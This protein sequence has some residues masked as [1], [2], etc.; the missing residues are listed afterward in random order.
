MALRQQKDEAWFEVEN[1]GKGIDEDD[2]PH[3]FERF[4]RGKTEEGQP[5]G[6]GLG[7]AIAKEITEKYGGSIHANSEPG[8]WTRIRVKL[9]LS[10]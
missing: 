3:V 5:T 10:H 2:L 9:P 7:L 4:Y 1:D 6:T 8:Q